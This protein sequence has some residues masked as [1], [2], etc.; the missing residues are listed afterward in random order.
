MITYIKNIIKNIIKSYEDLMRSALMCSESGCNGE[1]KH[2]SSRRS[3]CQKC[4][5]QYPKSKKITKEM[6]KQL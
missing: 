1:L 5:A 4:G 2:W 6:L 3:I